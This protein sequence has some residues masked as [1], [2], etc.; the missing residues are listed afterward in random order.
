MKPR[1]SCSCILGVVAIAGGWYFGTAQQPSGTDRASNAGKLM[2]PDLA[3]QAGQNAAR[4]RD[5]PPGQDHRPS[6]NTAMTWGLEDRGGYVVQPG[7]LRGMLT[8]LTELR[9]VEP[10]T[11]DPTEYN[12]LGLEDPTGRTAGIQPAAACSMPQA[13]R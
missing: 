10:R 12:R 7:K 1:T 2:F 11:T 13:S 4:D 3:P 5:R 8:A 6:S 9:L